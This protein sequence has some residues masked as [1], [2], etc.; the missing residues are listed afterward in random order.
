MKN[1]ICVT[2]I[3]LLFVDLSEA[4]TKFSSTDSSIETISSLEQA[5]AL[6][7]ATQEQFWQLFPPSDDW[8]YV[9]S[10]KSVKP[11]IWSSGWPNALKKQMSAEMRSVNGNLYPVYTLWAE[12]D[13]IT[14]DLTYY[15]MFGQ[16]VWIS[17][18]PL[19][20]TPLSSVLDRYG[21]ES[22]E[23]LSGSQQKFTASSVGLE[24]QLI[25]DGF[26]ESYE[27]DIVLEQQAAT[28]S[29]ESMAM[30]MMSVPM[31]GDEG[32]TG[33]NYNPT[34][35]SYS[36]PDYGDNLY[37]DQ[38][39]SS[40]EEGW[41]DLHNTDNGEEYEYYFTHNLINYPF[42]TNS[43]SFN[44]ARLANR[45]V[46]G[47][48][49]T[50]RWDTPIVGQNGLNG[51]AGFFRVYEVAH[52]DNDGLSDIYELMMTKTD[53]SLSNTGGTGQ[54]DDEKDLD[55]DGYTNLE[56]YMGLAGGVYTHPNLSDSDSD[57]FDDGVDAWPMDAAAHTDTD[58]DGMPDSFRSGYTTSSYPPLV[59]DE[60]DDNDGLSDTDEISVYGS[61][62]L[63]HDSMLD[64]DNDGVLN[65]LEHILGT[66]SSNPNDPG[67]GSC[68][69]TVISPYN[70]Q[71]LD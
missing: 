59:A 9:H 45:G 7:R 15:N 54:S 24:F 31:P 63:V 32:T 36:A 66:S 18:A 2:L 3:A 12:A 70:G 67:P 16:P 48:G 23:D 43:T 11:V 68:T 62:P 64:N 5:D 6:V 69:L 20:Y 22:V 55:G 38:N 41:L 4:A 19:G 10:D 51:I 65:I 26:Q 13:R 17:P 44:T 60:D 40:Y 46:Q 71:V 56:E 50:V 8:L 33:T 35:G 53:P 49:D 1:G 37:L 47:D 28:L 52:S 42:T 34:G 57:G 39:L 30:S 29:S 61:N 21:V 14:G 25:P 58:G 27:Q